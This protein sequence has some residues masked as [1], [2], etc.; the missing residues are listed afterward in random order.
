MSLNI[1]HIIQQENWL[2]DVNAPNFEQYALA[3]FRYQF[4]GNEVYRSFV[5]AIGRDPASVNSLT[6]IP[7][8]PISLFK[9]HE[10]LTGVRPQDTPLVFESSGTT[11]MQNSRHFVYDP[12]LYKASFLQTFRQFYGEPADYVFLC[13]LPSYLERNNSSL[14]Y[15]AAELIRQSQ[16]PESGFYLNE[17]DQLAANLEQLRTSGR[18]IMLLG[19]TFALLDF[20]DRY[21]MDLSQVTVMETGGMKGRREEWT[22]YQVHDFL[23]EKWQL[24]AVHSEYGMTELLSQAYSK[25]EGL[26]ECPPMMRVLVRDENDPFDLEL[27]GNG[28]INVIDLANVYSCAFIATDDVARIGADGRFAITGRLDHSALRGCSLMVV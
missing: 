20:A 24:P 14:V 11:G 13:L 27:R 17:W 8:L 12:G 6:D 22:R 26:F 5:T 3:L 19:V 10:V 23:K 1:E 7:F 16:Q 15:M 28:C 4:Q 25:G 2:S 9:T 21:P 18:K